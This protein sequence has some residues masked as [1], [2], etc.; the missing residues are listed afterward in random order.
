MT[1][2]ADDRIVSRGGRR[3]G[4]A[5]GA[6]RTLG[7]SAARTRAVDLAERLALVVAVA[8]AIVANVASHRVLNVASLANDLIVVFFVV[9]R[10]GA[11]TVSESPFD[12]GL[13]FVAS[14]GVL[15]M[16][17]GG[18]PLVGA[19]WTLALAVPGWLISLA[20]ILSLNRC[21]GVVAANRGIRAGGAYRIVRH[22]MYLGYFLNHTAYLLLNPTALNLG[23]WLGV[24]GCQV[25][26]ALREEQL[27]LRDPAYRAYAARVRF[28]IL[29]GLI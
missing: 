18:V 8:L 13:A 4:P 24:C 11:H 19:G 9:I 6:R 3:D 25:G 17:P 29:P 22:P 26:R 5:V 15:L 10:R 7:A 12:W 1:L 14:L 20:A 27:L 28:R 21:F 16:R 2:Q 23:V